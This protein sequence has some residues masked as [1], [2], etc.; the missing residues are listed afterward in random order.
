MIY[1]DLLLGC[2]QI[3]LVDVSLFDM[4]M[5]FVDNTLS[6]TEKHGYYLDCI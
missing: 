4:S 2:V 3:L 1:L 5:N 6:C